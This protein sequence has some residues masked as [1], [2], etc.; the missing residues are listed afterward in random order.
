MNMYELVRSGSFLCH[1]LGR[2]SVALV[3]SYKLNEMQSVWLT[4]GGRWIM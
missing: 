2:D 1:V 3:E 4:M